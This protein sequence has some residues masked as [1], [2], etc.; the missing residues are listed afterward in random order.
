MKIWKNAISD[1]K[2]VGLY[3]KIPFCKKECKN[4]PEQICENKIEKQC[5]NVP[6]EICEEVEIST[7]ARQD[8]IYDA[9][10]ENTDV[11]QDVLYDAI[12]EST[13][14]YF[15]DE[16]LEKEKKCHTEDEG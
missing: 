7:G 13:E 1:W 4:E 9:I 11:K 14:D 5:K 3:K 8:V 2:C 12:F 15:D 10:F 6:K 16:Q